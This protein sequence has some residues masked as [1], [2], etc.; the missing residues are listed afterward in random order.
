MVRYTI[1]DVEYILNNLLISYMDR[2]CKRLFEES[3]VEL[4]LTYQDIKEMYKEQLED[5]KSSGYKQGEVEVYMQIYRDTLNYLFKDN[6]E[7]KVPIIIERNMT[8][9]NEEMFIWGTPEI[10]EI[11]DYEETDKI[12]F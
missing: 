12:P 5:F 8:G 11:D 7:N 3:V 6:L 10:S 4:D 9:T 1:R 2:E